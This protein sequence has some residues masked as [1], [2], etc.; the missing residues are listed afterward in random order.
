MR[1]DEFRCTAAVWLLSDVLVDA[2]HET[3]S[4]VSGENELSFRSSCENRIKAKLLQYNGIHPSSSACYKIMCSCGRFYVGETCHF[5]RQMVAEHKSACKGCWVEKSELAEHRPETGH[6][7]E[8]SQTSGF[9]DYG[10]FAAKRK[11][12]EVI[13]INRVGN[14]LNVKNTNKKISRN[15]LCSIHRLKDREGVEP[16]AK[17][18]R[19]N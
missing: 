14:T 7:I 3:F 4:P 6:E 1:T 13:E 12:R 15:Y 8:W 10:V 17:R 5:I 18:M 16:H 11:I 9:A 19:R 2:V